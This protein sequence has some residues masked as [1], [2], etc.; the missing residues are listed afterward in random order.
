MRILSEAAKALELKPDS[1]GKSMLL[2]ALEDALAEAEE[3]PSFQKAI[4]V[5][6]LK[7][8]EREFEESV[9]PQTEEWGAMNLDSPVDYDGL[10][11]SME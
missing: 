8:K 7:A 5:S 3:D 6:L 9:K 10:W 11:E 1:Q 4:L 2:D